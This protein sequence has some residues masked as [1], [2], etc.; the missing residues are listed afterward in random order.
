MLRVVCSARA[1]RVLAAALALA[2]VVGTVIVLVTYVEG[3]L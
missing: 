2:V 1:R 3:S